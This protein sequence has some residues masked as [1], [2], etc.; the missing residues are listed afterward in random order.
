MLFNVRVDKCLLNPNLLLVLCVCVCVFFSFKT[1]KRIELEYLIL[2]LLYRGPLYMLYNILE[3]WSVKK[4]T[5]YV[6]ILSVLDTIKQ[7]TDLKRH[8]LGL[9]KHQRRHFNPCEFAMYSYC[10]RHV[11]LNGKISLVLL[12][13]TRTWKFVSLILN[14]TI[15][16][17]INV[18]III[19]RQDAIMLQ[20]HGWIDATI[21]CSKQDMKWA[22]KCCPVWHVV[23]L[24][25]ID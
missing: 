8:T 6:P 2:D 19:Q 16:C 14:E 7:I 17:E 3:M 13:M 24:N 15:F 1:F 9:E 18:M 10:R 21:K 4:L 20:I 23:L 5:I 12:S 22:E 11:L 25:W